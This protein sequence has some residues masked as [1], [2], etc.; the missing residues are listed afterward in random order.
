MHFDADGAQLEEHVMKARLVNV[1]VSQDIGNKFLVVA[2][3]SG[4]GDEGMNFHL[5]QRPGIWDTHLLRTENGLRG[6]PF[7]FSTFM[8]MYGDPAFTR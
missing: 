4:G 8:L 2:L 3:A 1:T 5:C 6:A 7:T